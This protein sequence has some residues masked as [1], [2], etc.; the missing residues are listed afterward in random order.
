MDVWGCDT[1]PM[2]GRGL[3]LPSW[4]GFSLVSIISF[5]WG[6]VKGA[7]GLNRCGERV[8]V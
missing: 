1:G 8:V 6:V 2:L 7:P 3:F 5:E 4:E